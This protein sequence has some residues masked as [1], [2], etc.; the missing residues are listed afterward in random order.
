MNAVEKRLESSK[1][2][3]ND[4]NIK[5]KRLEAEALDLQKEFE[6]KRQ[7]EAN[8]VSEYINAENYLLEL[9][10]EFT[11]GMRKIYANDIE[12]KDVDIEDL[13]FWE[14][15]SNLLYNILLIID[16]QKQFIVEQSN[17]AAIGGSHNY[18]NN[19]CII[20]EADNEEDTENEVSS[21]WISK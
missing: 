6:Q 11:N 10:D 2:L 4:Q 21:F 12:F 18:L 19:E 5:I 9:V 3:M 13:P 20:E 14:R 7:K 1:R 8:I 16:F 17:P 15:F